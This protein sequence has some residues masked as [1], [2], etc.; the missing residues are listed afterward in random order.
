MLNHYLRI[1]SF[2]VFDILRLSLLKP[3]SIFKIYGGRSLRG[4]AR[5]LFFAIGKILLYLQ[6]II[7]YLRV[8]FQC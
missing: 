4:D 6:C 1:E 5:T 7:G 2:M 3:E 8:F